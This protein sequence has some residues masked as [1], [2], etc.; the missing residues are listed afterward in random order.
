MNII[1]DIINKYYYY[2]STANIN[3]FTYRENITQHNTMYLTKQ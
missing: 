3:D 2:N 1:S